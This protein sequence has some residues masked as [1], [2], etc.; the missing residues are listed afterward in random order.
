LTDPEQLLAANHWQNLQA[1]RVAANR[2]KNGKFNAGQR[3]AYLERYRKLHGGP[4][5]EDVEAVEAPF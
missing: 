3:D 2:E 4:A 1:L 5:A